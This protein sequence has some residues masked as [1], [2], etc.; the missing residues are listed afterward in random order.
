[1]KRI[2]VG[3]FQAKTH[4]S[5]LLDEVEKGAVVTITRRGKPVAVIRQDDSA[6][7][8]G[9]LEAVRCLRTLC[10]VKIPVEEI[11]EL[12]EEGRER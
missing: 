11:A 8:A 2:Q 12:R 7:R 3:A 6:A 1:M 9:A 10:T 4:L 5:Q